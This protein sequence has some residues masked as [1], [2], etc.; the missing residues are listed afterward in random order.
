M[1]RFLRNL[2]V[3]CWRYR[4]NIRNYPGLHFT[5][6]P[7]TCDVL[8]ELLKLLE[9][10]GHNAHRAVPLKILTISD[11]AKI[12]GG[13]KYRSFSKLKIVFCLASGQLRQASFYE[14]NGVALFYLTEN[15]MDKFKAGLRDIKEGIGDYSIAPDDKKNLSGEMDKK[16]EC[17]WFWPCF[18]HLFVNER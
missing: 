5:A 11:E 7:M 10:E 13:Q 9:T 12:T 3:W 1:E 15:F 14:E 8:L 4:E 16:S 17:L 2:D 18:G 6:K